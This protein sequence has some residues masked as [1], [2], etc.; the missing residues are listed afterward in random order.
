MSKI[1]HIRYSD[2]DSR[3]RQFKWTFFTDGSALS[4]ELTWHTGDPARPVKVTWHES[5]EK[6]SDMATLIGQMT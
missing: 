3:D 1:S 4:E 2:R 5:H 6:D